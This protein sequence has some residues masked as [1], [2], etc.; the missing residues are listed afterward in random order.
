MVVIQYGL[1]NILDKYFEDFK[2][3]FFE[4]NKTENRPH[5][6]SFKDKDDIIWFVPI[7]SQVEKYKKKIERDE[8]K[9]GKDKCIFYY[10][11]KIAG[12]ESVFL[13]GN[14]FPVT[15]KYIKK[16]Y[17]LSN[18]HYIVKNKFDIN[19][20]NKRINKYLILVEMGKIKS[21]ID[22]MKIKDNLLK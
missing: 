3:D 22:I 8:E 20:I 19:N 2:N 17:T 6:L 4:D 15:E 7:S 11:C 16:P 10:I 9:Y 13:I 1:Y 12:S 21:K 14:M 18:V 5:Y